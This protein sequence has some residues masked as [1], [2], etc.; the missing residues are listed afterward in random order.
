MNAMIRVARVAL[1]LILIE[2]HFVGEVV[3]RTSLTCFCIEIISNSYRF[4]F[5]IHH[6]QSQIILLPYLLF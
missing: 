3:E 4:D 5:K 1:Q 2:G 6:N